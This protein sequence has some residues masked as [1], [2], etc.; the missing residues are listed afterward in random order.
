MINDVK[1][2]FLSQGNSINDGITPY[3]PTITGVSEGETIFDE[4]KNTCI[5]NV[6]TTKEV[7]EMLSSVK[8]T[9][10]G[11]TVDNGL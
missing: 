11:L 9:Y 4:K 8:P 2:E 3:E 1:L 10:S 6:H 5:V 7:R